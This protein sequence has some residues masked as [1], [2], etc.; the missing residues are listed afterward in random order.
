MLFRDTE[1]ISRRNNRVFRKL[2]PGEEVGGARG[3]CFPLQTY[4]CCL[5]LQTM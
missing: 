3:C 2:E 4:E 5:L 1:I